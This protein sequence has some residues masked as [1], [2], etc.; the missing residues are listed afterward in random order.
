MVRH[1]QFIQSAAITKSFYS[2]STTLT[3]SFLVPVLTGQRTISVRADVGSFSPLTA[4]LAPQ[5]C[6]LIKPLPSSPLGL[7]IVFHC[8]EFTEWLDQ[9]QNRRHLLRTFVSHQTHPS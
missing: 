5:T 6:L 8:A 1:S 7:D 4:T 3:T 9:R 2:S